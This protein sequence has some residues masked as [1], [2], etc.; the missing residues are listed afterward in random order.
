[1]K[2]NKR[3]FALATCFAIFNLQA[4]DNKIS[5]ATRLSTVTVNITAQVVTPDEALIIFGIHAAQNPFEYIKQ[6]IA[7]HFNDFIFTVNQVTYIVQSQNNTA[8]VTPTVTPNSNMI[9]TDITAQT[10]SPEEAAAII[11]GAAAL[12]FAE[13]CTDNPVQ[14][15]TAIFN[16]S[17]NGCMFTIDGTTYIIQS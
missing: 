7:D 1:M 5:D 2:M 8:P 12:Y 3:I 9:T 15:V 11:A 6:L 14:F 17:H 16:Q 10:V 4:H 13:N